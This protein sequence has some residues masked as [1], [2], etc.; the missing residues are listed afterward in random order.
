MARE[1]HGVRWTDDLAWMEDMKGERWNKHVKKE[2]ARWK[3]GIAACNTSKELL[4]KELQAATKLQEASLFSAS[5]NQLVIGYTS[6]VS[7]NWRWAD[8]EEKNWAGELDYCK[9]H[10]GYVWVAEETE[11]SEGAE[12]YQISCYKKG[13]GAVWRHKG[14]GAYCA[15]VSGRCYALE[16]ANRLWHYKLVSWDCI[17]GKDK[18]VHYEERDSRYNLELVKGSCE[19]AVLRR[20]AGLLQDCFWIRKDGLTLI[21]GISLESRRFVFDAT[22]PENYYYWSSQQGWIANGKL[23]PLHK[24]E[25]PE[26]LCLEKD[27]LIMRWRGHRAIWRS[28]KLLWNDVGQILVDPWDSQWVRITVPGQEV[29]WW[30]ASA[31]PS[32]PPKSMTRCRRIHLWRTAGETPYII[33][34]PHQQKPTHVMIYGYGAY[35]M[36]T[37]LSTSRWEPLL[38]RGWALAIPMWRGGGD[39]TPEW[40]DAGRR[41]GREQVLQDAEEVI[42]DIQDVTGCSP[43]RTWI[44]GRSAGGLW[45]GG[46]VARHPYGDLF[47]GA[48]MEVPYVDVLA[49]TSNRELPLTNMEADEFGLP[50]ARLSDFIGITRWSPMEQLVSLK[51]PPTVWQLL[52][53]GLNDSQVYAYEAAKW[54]A[55]SGPHAFLAIEGGQG[56]FANGSVGI[57]QE[58]EDL[59]AILELAQR[60][61]KNRSRVYK[62]AN[63]RKNKVNTRKNR[64]DR[65]ESRKN[66]KGTRKNRKASRKNRK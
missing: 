24:R 42:R 64:K 59:A 44:F 41:G 51:K 49:T 56:H 1:L 28:G 53:T 19:T 43:T 45:V 52:R 4:E 46:T 63:M 8:E 16:L 22:Q 35:G 9:L 12:Q 55:R 14:V 57:R 7:L 29:M 23:R 54:V 50:A 34:Y 66:R 40:E 6:R 21:D 2:Q 3:A 39:H 60:P 36:V 11:E 47:G 15:V 18:Q 33:V 61:I 20:Q 30:D 48:Y 27:L 37:P 25:V 17:T 10:P 26:Y 31:T 32:P 38:H 5:N 58:A 65:K 13:K 62:M